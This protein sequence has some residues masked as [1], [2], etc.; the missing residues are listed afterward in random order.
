MA[1]NSIFHY[2]E[3][4]T[5]TEISQ[6][7]TAEKLDE[8]ANE[9]HRQNTLHFLNDET[10]IQLTAWCLEFASVLFE[11]RSGDNDYTDPK[12][13]RDFEHDKQILSEL[14]QILSGSKEKT[15]QLETLL[16]EYDS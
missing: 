12:T 1:T 6:T 9:V 8:L 5:I 15:Q 16:E 3:D 14:D 11:T 13:S 10:K 4:A 2:P 7:N